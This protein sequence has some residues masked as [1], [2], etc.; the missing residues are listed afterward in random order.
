MRLLVPVLRRDMGR[1]PTAILLTSFRSRRAE[2]FGG[3]LPR[4]QAGAARI[5]NDIRHGFERATHNFF[6]VA[7][8]VELLTRKELRKGCWDYGACPGSPI[9]QAGGDEERAEK[10]LRRRSFSACPSSIPF[11]L[12]GFEL[13]PTTWWR[14]PSRTTRGRAHWCRSF[15]RVRTIPNLPCGGEIDRRKDKT[16][17][18]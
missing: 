8:D 12:G 14:P 10:P 13:A 6:N 9:E 16:H 18:Y 7:S 2:L 11:G 17:I 1:K 4:R 15:W 3:G 5:E